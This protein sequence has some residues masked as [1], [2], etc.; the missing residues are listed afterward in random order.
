MRADA[1]RCGWTD[2][3]CSKSE[4]QTWTLDELTESLDYEEGRPRPK[5]PSPLAQ[6]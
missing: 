2:T 3:T 1:A 6:R 4:A 5:E